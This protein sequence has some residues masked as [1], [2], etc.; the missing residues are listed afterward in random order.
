MS[1]RGIRGATTVNNNNKD[2]ILDETKDLMNQMIE[3]NNI[4]I[5]DIASIFFS[6]TRDLDSVFPA[7]AARELNMNNTP[8]LCLN[9]VNVPGSLPKCIRILMHVNTAKP[10]SQIKHIYLNDAVSLRP[11]FAQ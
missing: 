7:A 1:V 9:E 6:V 4:P 8:L 11:E 3:T 10:Q 2:N 5:D